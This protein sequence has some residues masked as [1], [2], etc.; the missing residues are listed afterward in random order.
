MEYQ[1]IINL[2]ENITDQPSKSRTKKWVL[3]K[4]DTHTNYSTS[5]EVKFKTTKFR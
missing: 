1:K 5:T 2:L 4:D 3:V